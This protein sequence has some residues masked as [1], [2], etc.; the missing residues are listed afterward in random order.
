MLGCDGRVMSTVSV[1]SQWGDK[2]SSVT[3]ERPFC[4][5]TQM[6]TAVV[7]EKVRGFCWYSAAVLFFWQDT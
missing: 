2:E 1:Q 7:G 3:R 6:N 4:V 5:M